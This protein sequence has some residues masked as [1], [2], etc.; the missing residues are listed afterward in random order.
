MTELYG[1]AHNGGLGFTNGSHIIL[2]TKRLGKGDLGH[3]ITGYS[4]HITWHLN[5][6]RKGFDSPFGISWGTGAKGVTGW[7]KMYGTSRDDCS[8]DKDA[9]MGM[10][11]SQ[12]DMT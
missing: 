6:E 5:G 10:S 1:G 4:G 2:G 12:M 8:V 3:T 11:T 9:V 7:R